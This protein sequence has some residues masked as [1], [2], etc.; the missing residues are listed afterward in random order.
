MLMPETPVPQQAPIQFV[1]P[2]RTLL[3]LMALLV[4]AVAGSL[5]FIYLPRA[6]ITVHPKISSRSVEQPMILSAEAKEPD[7][8]RYILP[9]KLVEKEVREAKHITRE[10]TNVRDDFA[11]GKITLKNDQGEEQPL[12]PKT[13]LRHEASGTFF[14]TDTAVTIPPQGEVA[15]LVTAKEAGPAGNVPAGKFIVDKLPTSLQAVVYGESAQAFTGGV[16]SDTPLAAADINKT[17]EEVINAAKEKAFG[18]ITLESGGAGIRPELLTTEVVLE[19]ISAA[20]GSYAT[21]YDV[22][23]TVRARGLVVDNNDLLSLTLLALR[24]QETADEEFLSYDPDSFDLTITKADIE[25]GQTQVTGKLSGTFASKIGP[26]ILSTENLAGLSAT[27]ATEHF[28]KFPAVQDAQVSFSPF[29]VRSIPSRPQ[30]IEI[31]IANKP[32]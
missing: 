10:A 21:G 4:L 15:T 17:K 31:V 30:A 27:E 25:R 24:N 28:K 13:H 5:A 32:Q 18:E 20:P 26:S 7:F 8:I 1:I 6:H 12:L 2:R 11:T 9:A 3:L 16:A 19:Q 14:L 22:D 23:I 29:W